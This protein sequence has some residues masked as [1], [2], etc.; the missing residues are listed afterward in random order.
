MQQQLLNLR[1]VKAL[2]KAAPAAKPSLC[3]PMSRASPSFHTRSRSAFSFY[4][5]A[6]YIAMMKQLL[7]FF[8]QEKQQ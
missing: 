6:L 5:R 3:L 4:T 2:E 7:L 8:T 1:E